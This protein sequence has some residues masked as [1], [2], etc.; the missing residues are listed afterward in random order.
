MLNIDHNYMTV[1]F[2]ICQYLHKMVDI[3]FVTMEMRVYLTFNICLLCISCM[4]QSYTLGW[5]NWN[6]GQN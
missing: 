4:T 5:K 6:S 3:L 2:H 1:H